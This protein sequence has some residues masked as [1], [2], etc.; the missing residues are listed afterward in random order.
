MKKTQNNSNLEWREEYILFGKKKPPWDLLYFDI[1][2]R[3][4]GLMSPTL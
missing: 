3:G 4:L 2:V 1:T